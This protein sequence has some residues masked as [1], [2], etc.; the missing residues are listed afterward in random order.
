MKTALYL[1]AAMAVALT[2][3]AFAQT[4]EEIERSTAEQIAGHLGVEPDAYTLSELTRLNCLVESASTEA[5][6]QR[7]LSDPLSMEPTVDTGTTQG[8]EQIAASLGVNAGDYTTSQ[9]ALLKTLSED[10]SCNV[11]DIEAFAAGGEQV[12]VGSARAKLQL[13]TSLGV[14]P[15][16]HTLAELVKMRFDT[17]RHENN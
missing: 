16:E 11:G 13:A 10:D 9:L 3:G 12:T 14:D 2:Q 6:R 17:E 5:E 8:D 15:S 1:S 7:L 4:L